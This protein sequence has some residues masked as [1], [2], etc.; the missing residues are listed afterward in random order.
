MNQV[1]KKKKNIIDREKF[2][3]YAKSKGF[4]RSKI[5]TSKEFIDCDD[6]FLCDQM[7]KNEL[8]DPDF[9]D[10]IPSDGVL[11]KSIL[12][13]SFLQDSIMA[14]VYAE[15]GV[16]VRPHKHDKGF[17]RVVHQGELIMHCDQLEGGKISIF[18]G[19]W[20]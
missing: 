15:P 10:A 12:P 6:D 18:P 9:A 13:F 3:I 16:E 19:D 2:D 5:I 8:I 17:F 14:M 11:R 1:I 20:I 4:D 7:V